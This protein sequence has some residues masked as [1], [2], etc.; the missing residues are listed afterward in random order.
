MTSTAAGFTIHETI[1]D[2]NR[3]FAYPCE[4]NKQGSPQDYY[5]R[6]EEPEEPEELMLEESSSIYIALKKNESFGGLGS[7]YKDMGILED[8]RA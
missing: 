4:L 5:T 2:L 1:E 3:F 8:I 6:I 7:H